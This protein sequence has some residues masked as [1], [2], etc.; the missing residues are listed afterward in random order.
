MRIAFGASTSPTLDEIFIVFEQ[1]GTFN[2]TPYLDM[3]YTKADINLVG[4]GGGGGAG[5]APSTTYAGG[6][7]GAG[8]GGCYLYYPGLYLPALPAAGPVIVG[9]GCFSGT[10]VAPGTGGAT[11]YWS[12]YSYPGGSGGA[13]GAAGATYTGNG[14]GGGAGGSIVAAGANGVSGATVDAAGGAGAY[15]GGAGGKG[16]G[17][18]VAGIGGNGT[19]YY[20]QLY[21][22]RGG[23]GGGGG[24]K[25]AL[26][27]ASVGP[28]KAGGDGRA[29]LGGQDVAAY[30]ASA[31]NGVGG[32]GGGGGGGQD[33]TYVNGILDFPGDGASGGPA[34]VNTSPGGGAT[35][36][37]GAITGHASDPSSASGSGLVIIRLYVQ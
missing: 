27:N 4:A 6:G 30:A 29:S 25:G 22:S 10:T 11:A 16:F 5:G 35:G 26:Q 20:A 33:M 1:S 8:G 12:L 9:R 23:G 34:I 3:G 7:G 24:G 32:G 28:G 17:Y 36:A 19:D 18:A 13:G 21:A 37:T 31:S 14:G 15:G 2:T